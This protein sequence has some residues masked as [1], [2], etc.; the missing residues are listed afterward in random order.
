MFGKIVPGV[1]WPLARFGSRTS[2][3]ANPFFRKLYAPPRFSGVLPGSQPRGSLP[4]TPEEEKP[5]KM[6]K[7]PKAILKFTKLV[8]T[9]G[10]IKKKIPILEWIIGSGEDIIEGDG[11]TRTVSV[12]VLRF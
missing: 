10:E 2:V 5:Y 3:P 8:I 9:N 12:K 1:H 6:Y 11:M 7:I 4:N